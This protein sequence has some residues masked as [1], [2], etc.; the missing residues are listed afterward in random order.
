MTVAKHGAD[1][2]SELFAAAAAF[3]QFAVGELVGL[4]TS[5]M[6]AATIDAIFTPALFFEESETGGFVGELLLEGE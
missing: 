5:T 6:R 2:D 4:H 1:F 3:E